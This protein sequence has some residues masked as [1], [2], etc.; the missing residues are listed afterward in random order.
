MAT[1]RK[2]STEPQNPPEFFSRQVREARRFYLDLNPPPNVRLAVVCGG[3]E[4]CAVDYAIQR[5]SFPYFCL[6]M[7]AGGA[8][9]LVLGGQEHSIW[10]GTVFIYGP[11]IAQ[12]ITTSVEEPLVKYFV[13]FS[14]RHVASLLR[15]A[16]LV[17]G[18]VYRV[19]GPL[20]IEAVFDELIQNGLKSTR[21]SPALCAALA[22]YLILKIAESLLPGGTVPSPSF[23][24]YQRCRQHLQT[25][26]AKIKTLEEAAAEC[27]VDP[28]YLCRLF[29][30]FDHQTP[31]Q[32]LMR[33]KMNLAAGR[34]QEPGTLVKHVAAELG[35]DDSCH[36]SRSFKAVFGMS[37]ESFR[38]LQ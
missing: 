12:H 19:C 38:R 8:G 27:H 4:R 15:Q 20:E 34:L 24:T 35:F 11:G 18:S 9:S 16:N 13:N 25:Q 5:A 28:A 33:L 1:P 3:C 36:F 2:S 21:H 31:Y 23:A 6:E 10:P 32:L 14:G 37:P 30:R 29:R 17:L 22:E 26:C 7:V